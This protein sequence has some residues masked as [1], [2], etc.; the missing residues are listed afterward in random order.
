MT[1]FGKNLCAGML[2]VNVTVRSMIL[3]LISNSLLYDLRRPMSAFRSH[4]GRAPAPGSFIDLR[5]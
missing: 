1:G 5:D 3:P 4:H 2:F